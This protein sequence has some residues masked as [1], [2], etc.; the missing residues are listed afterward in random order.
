MLQYDSHKKAVVA[1][2]FH[3][4]RI[5]RALRSDGPT[6]GDCVD[7]FRADTEWPQ[8]HFE[9]SDLEEEFGYTRHTISRPIPPELAIEL[10]DSDGGP[11]TQKFTGEHVVVMPRS[12]RISFVSYTFVC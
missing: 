4:L 12:V 9:D 2:D 1:H 6:R 11:E 7:V 8:L 10:E 5:W 3:P